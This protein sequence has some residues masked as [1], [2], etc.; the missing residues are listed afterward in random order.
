MN[1]E[2]TDENLQTVADFAAGPDSPFRAAVP[3]VTPAQIIEAMRTLE[4][5]A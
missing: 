3:G 1:L 2:F 4:T 5:L